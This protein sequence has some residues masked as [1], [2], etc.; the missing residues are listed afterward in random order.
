MRVRPLNQ[1]VDELLASPQQHE[2]RVRM[3]YYL[4][5]ILDTKTSALLTFNSVVLAVLA[6]AAGRQGTGTSNIVWFGM[7]LALFACLLCFSVVGVKWHFLDYR[8]DLGTECEDLAR[9]VDSRTAKYKV[10]WALSALSMAV[11]G[12]SILDEWGV[13]R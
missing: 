3:Y 8:V 5:D 6:L 4:L 10:S 11:L 7:L 13:L 2:P 12:W 1:A 9:V